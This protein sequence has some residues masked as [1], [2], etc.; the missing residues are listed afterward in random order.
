MNIWRRGRADGGCN[1]TAPGRLFRRR[2]NLGLCTSP[3]PAKLIYR[4]MSGTAP[5]TLNHHPVCINLLSTSL[6][7]RT[8]IVQAASP[9][10]FYTKFCFLL[11][12]TRVEASKGG[13]IITFLAKSEIQR[14][15]ESWQPWANRLF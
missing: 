7:Q 14:A 2:P 10:L 3:V 1:A 9:L 12:I 6:A 5:R 13:C 15:R 8:S 4:G 11:P